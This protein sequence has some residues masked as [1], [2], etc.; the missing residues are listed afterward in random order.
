MDMSDEI[1]ELATPENGV[2]FVMIDFVKPESGGF[3]FVERREA[4][5]PPSGVSL[6]TSGRAECGCDAY[7]I[8]R[9]ALRF[10]ET[11]E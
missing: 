6:C 4:L 1:V 8:D 5:C 7:A 3:V 9:Y 11:S 10:R 2:C